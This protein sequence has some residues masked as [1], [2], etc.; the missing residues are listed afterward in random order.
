MKLQLEKLRRE[1]LRNTLERTARLIE[2]MELQLEELVSGC[3]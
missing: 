3:P 2:Q 1:F